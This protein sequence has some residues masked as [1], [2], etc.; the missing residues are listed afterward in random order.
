MKE[1]VIREVPQIAAATERK[2]QAWTFSQDIAE[3]V[4]ESHRV[5]QSHRP[6]GSFIT[7][8][9]EAGAGGSEVA[10][11]V[12]RRLGWEVFDRNLLDCVAQRFRLSRDMLEH[13][14]E[15]GSHWAYD[16]LGSFIEPRIVPHA[17]FVVYLTQVVLAAARRG[18]V[19]FVGRGAQF[20]LP[21]GQGLAARI[22][23]PLKYRLEHVERLHGLDEAAAR[24]FIERTDQGRHEFAQNFFQHDIADPHLYDLVI[25]VERLGL[26][27]AVEQILAAHCSLARAAGQR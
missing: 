9:R 5:D 4:R 3:R 16:V 23:A 19:V 24:H 22:V 21:H 14:D 27:G 25:N 7:L 1:S 13:V 17:K 20:I 18:N 6:L 8:S 26:E 11:A 15:T 2:M 10:L 12:G